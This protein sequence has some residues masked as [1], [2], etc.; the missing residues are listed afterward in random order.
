MSSQLLVTDFGAVGDGETLCTEAIQAALD[1]AGETGGGRVVVPAGT[2]RTGTLHLR[3]RVTLEIE[4]GGTLIGSGDMADYPETDWQRD[5]DRHRHHLLIARDVENVTITGGGT[6][7]GNGPAFW[8]PQKAPRAWIGARSPRVSPMIE[9]RDCS[10]VRLVDVEIV[11]SPGWTVHLLRCDRVW[12]RGVKLQNHLFGP[13]TDGFDVNGCRDVMISDCNIVCGDDAIVLKTT[14]DSRSLERVT[15]TNC[16]IRTH[17][18]GLK[19][20]ANESIHD[21]RQITFSNCVVYGSTRAVG[22]YNWRGCMEEDIV[23]SNIVCDTDS[24]FILNRPIHIDARHAEFEPGVIRNVQISNV[25]ARTDGRILMTAADGYRVQNVLLRDVRL[26]YPAI[27]DPAPTAP[28]AGSAQFS[29]HSPEARAARAAVV[30]DGIDNLVIEGL[31]I[32]WPSGEPPASWSGPKTENGS[33]RVHEPIEAEPP[34]FAAI[35][36][37]RLSGGLIHCPLARASR[38]G[39][40]KFDLDD[41]DIQVR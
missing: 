4:T 40:E 23:V 10:D 41:S 24:G 38:D 25:V 33:D 32:D 20:G 30:A 14:A 18:V 21:M 9:I 17:C 1:K 15:V 29:N 31:F 13:N 35:W 3:S 7:D 11:N 8:K 39:H 19:L 22:I 2:F 27:D 16:V 37:R 28:G 26:T 12:V 6:I 34:A 36:G 5:G